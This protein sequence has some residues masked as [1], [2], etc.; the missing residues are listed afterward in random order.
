MRKLRGGALK[1]VSGS[2]VLSIVFV[3]L[4]AHTVL[5]ALVWADV[6]QFASTDAKVAV[7]TILTVIATLLAIYALFLATASENVCSVA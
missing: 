4:I 6:I 1:S 2:Q 5:A 3:L 7:G